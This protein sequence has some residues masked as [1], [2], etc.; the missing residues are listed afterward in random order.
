MKCQP[1]AWATHWAGG[2]FFQAGDLILRE[3]GRLD[4]MKI[5]IVKAPKALGSILKRIFHLS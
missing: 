3:K 4:A 2:E 1:N 5:A